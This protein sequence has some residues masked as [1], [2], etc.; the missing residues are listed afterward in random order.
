MRIIGKTIK[1]E[2]KKMYK[3]IISP[4]FGNYLHF[5][6]ATSVIGSLTLHKRKGAVKQFLKTFRFYKGG[7]VNKIGLRNSGIE[8]LAKKDFSYYDNKI[9]SLAVVADLEWN[10]LASYVKNFHKK[11]FNPMMLE[12]NISCPNV[13]HRVS[14]VSY[15]IKKF[16]DIGIKLCL[17][18]P[19]FETSINIIDVALQN[20]VTTFHLSN[21]IPSGRGGV[22][23]SLLKKESL[24]LIS[25]VRE[26]F[27]DKIEI[28]GG[29]GI[30]STE[31]IDLYKN[32]G[33]DIFSISTIVIKNPFK[34][35]SIIRK[36]LSL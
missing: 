26:K 22:S 4:P 32:A 29:G 27:G 6:N 30:Y 25:L 15:I 11:G 7:F 34:I 8:S 3:V 20:G 21:T 1:C 19:P 17:K 33:A 2:I 10:G 23:G 28:I 13:N 16:S 24:K 9:V 14:D 31:D 5:K 36:S 12:L 35:K 18:L